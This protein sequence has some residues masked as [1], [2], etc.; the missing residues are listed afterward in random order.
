MKIHAITLFPEGLQASTR[1]GVVGT[2]FEK[3]LMELTTTN[4]REFTSDIHHSVD[5]RPFGGG[6]G[7]IMSCEPLAQAITRAKMQLPKAKVYYLSAQGTPWT[8]ARAQAMATREEAI[9]LCGRYGGIDQRVINQW[10]DEEIC[11]GD[12]VLSGGE[13][14]A[15]VVIDSVARWVPGVL[16]H[17]A[18]ASEDSF[19]GVLQG[20]LEAPHFTRPLEWQGQKVPGVLTSGHHSKIQEW[21]EKVGK[22]VTLKSRPELFAK[23]TPWQEH[24]EL[25]QFLKSLTQEELQS[26]GLAN[27]AAEGDFLLAKRKKVP[28]VAVGLLHYPIVDREKDIVATNITNFDI[29]DIAR[30]CTVYGIEQYYLIHPMDEQLMFVDRILDHWRTGQGAKFNPS[31]K[32]ALENVTPVKTLEEALKNWGVSRDQVTILATHARVVGGARAYTIEEIRSHMEANPERCFFLLFGTGFGMTDEYMR[33]MDGVLEPLRGA[34]PKDFRHLSVRS[35][36]SIYLDR[37]L[38]PW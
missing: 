9:L 11:I 28:R 32:R 34:P 2:A 16:G 20:G 21:R 35:A 18:S 13:L 12:Y 14:A 6:D 1:M 29:H 4:P 25:L 26:L 15:A 7:M 3:K 24:T 22:L 19:S 17:A 8:S 27:L 38:G 33:G 31:R 10:V 37:V 30:A 23:I 5:D 36:V